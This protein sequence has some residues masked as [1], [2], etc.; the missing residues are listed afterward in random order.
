MQNQNNEELQSNRAVFGIL[1][2]VDAGKTT[3]AES[4]LY[5]TGGIRSLGRVDHKNAFLDTYEMEKQRGITIFS[6]QA[7][8]VIRQGNQQLAVTLMDTPGH[9]DFSAEMER[10]LQILDY[11][12][13]VINGMDGIQAHVMTLW[14]LLKQYC[15]PVFLFVNKMDQN[16]TDR[17][18]LMEELTKQLS[19]NCVAFDSVELEEH[20]AMCDETLMNTY[21]ETNEIPLKLI[22]KAIAER[23]VFPCFFGSALK[24][25]GVPELLNS[26]L[27]YTEKKE[28]PEAFS[29]RVFKIARDSVGNRLTY[30]KLIGGSLKVKALFG[31]EKADQLRIYSG[32]QYRVALEAVAGEVVAVTGLNQTYAG[33]GFGLA[34]KGKDPVLS[35]VLTYQI[36]L[37]P[38]TDVHDTYRK[39]VQ[40]EEE[41]PQ[42]HLLW[43]KQSNAIHAQVMG[44]IQVEVL[45]SLIQ[46][47]YHL[48]VTFGAGSIVY[49]ETIAEPIIGVGH[50]EPLRHYAEVHVLITPGERGSGIQIDSNVSEDDLDKN[51]QRLIMTHLAEREHK[52]VLTGAP[53]T[54]V[55]LTLV[56]GRAHKKHTEGGDFREAT[57]RAVR[58]GLKSGKSVLLEPMYGFQ[59]QVPVETVGRAMSDIERR[60]GKCQPPEVIG[61]TATLHGVA[62]VATMQGYPIEVAAYTRGKG[63]LFCSLKGYEPCHNA[64]EVIAAIGYNSESDLEHPTG[65]VFCAHGA[66]FLVEWNKVSEYMHLADNNQPKV[67]VMEDQPVVPVQVRQEN[68]NHKKQT[69]SGTVGRYSVADQE[70]A[71]IFNRTYG[72][73]TEKNRFEPEAVLQ[74]KPTVNKVDIIPKERV[75]EY[76]LVDGYNIIFS[77][78][79]LKKLSESNLEAAR[80]KLMDLLC[81]YQGF[82]KCTLILVFDAYK[83][84]GSVGQIQKYHNIYVVYTKEAET[85]DQYIEKTV[86]EIGRKYQV[87]VATSDA[88]EQVIIWGAGA[89]RMSA[90]GLHDEVQETNKA[91]HRLLEQTQ[92]KTGKQ[93]VKLLPPDI[94]DLMEDIRLGKRTLD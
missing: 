13:L 75:E 62:P 26:L 83:V 60:S 47:R 71:E 36:I 11:A 78:D 51:W 87:T 22:Q 56:A 54:D 69:I 21:L 17:T 32:A 2:H 66:G 43:E 40:L 70:L 82:K 31:E 91:I 63:R 6:K 33:Q 37:P 46:E 27:L 9:S 24:L 64:E 38:N 15:I 68:S 72:T 44:E 77:W 58:Q 25:D 4:L 42:L 84:E 81:N 20:L 35:P 34:E 74:R 12:I 16:G 76:L 39:L 85:A 65:S 8:L 79:E 94:A 90:A 93:L 49:K 52:G 53:L 3:L 1:A 19:E 18:K 80:Q 92:T 23:K 45:K 5:L 59:L 61:D 67:S 48:D 57:Y 10:T 73:R 41:E 55:H 7:E 86:H 88:T 50:F 30:M 14:K 29:A 89:L 28:Y